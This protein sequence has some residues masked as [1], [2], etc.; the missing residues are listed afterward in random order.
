VGGLLS[1]PVHGYLYQSWGPWAPM[2][3]LVAALLLDATLS[4]WA[5]GR[6]S[7]KPVPAGGGLVGH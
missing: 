6:G 5:L 4:L 7:E 3:A 1:T 2:G